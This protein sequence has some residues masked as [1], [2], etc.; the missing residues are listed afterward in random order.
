L[1]EEHRPQTLTPHG[2]EVGRMLGPA[3]HELLDGPQVRRLYMLAFIE[4]PRN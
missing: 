3:F 2:Q 1:H 4:R